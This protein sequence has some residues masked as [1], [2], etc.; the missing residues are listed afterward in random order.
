MNL[1]IRG[2][3]S[4]SRFLSLRFSGDLHSWG[5]VPMQGD[6]SSPTAL[7]Q[8]D[9]PARARHTCHPAGLWPRREL[10][11]SKG[12]RGKWEQVTLPPA[13][14]G[15]EAARDSDKR[16]QPPGPICSLPGTSS[17]RRETRANI[18]SCSWSLHLIAKKIT[19]LNICRNTPFA[20][21]S[22]SRVFPGR[23]GAD[24]Q[25]AAGLAG[26]PALTSK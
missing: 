11:D 24:S 9:I 6:F 16:R 14:A 22:K 3:D 17:Y 4:Q 10:Q 15:M 19:T 1:E 7:S 26:A 25:A 13:R 8:R 5:R 20:L 18:F 23:S 21:L 2:P 12:S